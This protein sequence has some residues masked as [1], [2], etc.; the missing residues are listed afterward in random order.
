M[1]FTADISR[2][3]AKKKIEIEQLA[4]GTIISLFTAVIKDTPVDEGRLQ[5]NWQT[6]ANSPAPGKKQR[7]GPGGAIA[8]AHTTVTKPGI[9]YLTNNLPY[10]ETIEFDGH[11]KTKAPAGMVRKNVQRLES[12]LRKQ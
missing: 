3:A 10:A 8:E 6:T 9:H 12:I 5:G 7:K 11:S 1:S 2:I 4:R